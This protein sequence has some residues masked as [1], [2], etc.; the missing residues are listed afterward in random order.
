M[1]VALAKDLGAMIN[2][3][4]HIFANVRQITYEVLKSL[5]E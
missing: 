4:L 5:E 2:E 1:N 3:L